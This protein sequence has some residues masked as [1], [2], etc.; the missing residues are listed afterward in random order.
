MKRNVMADETEIQDLSD[1]SAPKTGLAKLSTEERE[2]IFQTVMDQMADSN[3]GYE[4]ICKNIKEELDFRSGEQWSEEDRALREGRPCLTIDKM[5]KYLDKVEGYFRNNPPQANVKARFNA[6]EDDAKII[7]GYL[8]SFLASP[9]T[10][11]CIQT[12]CGH[13]TTVGYGWIYVNYEK[14]S[15]RSFDEYSPVATRVDDPRS[16]RIDKS[17]IEADGSDAAWVSLL[18]TMPRKTAEDR[19]DEELLTSFD[20]VPD[21]YASQWVKDDQI[22]VADYWWKEDVDDTLTEITT[23]D[24]NQK[25]RLFS[26]ELEK[27]VAGSYTVLRTAAA[28]RSVVKMVTVTGAGIVDYIEWPGSDLPII[29]CY[30]AQVWCGEYKVYT[31]LVRKAMD[32]QRLINYYASATAE[33]T[34]LAPR[35]P[36]ILAEQQKE[37]HEAEWDTATVDNF[38]NLTYKHVDGIATPQRAQLTSD[39]SPLLAAITNSTNDLAD[40]MG[41]YEASLG[42]ESNQKSGTAIQN[43]SQNSDQV[44]AIMIDNGRRAVIRMAQVAVN[45]LP[46]LATEE[47]TLRYLSEEGEESE[48]PVNT[49]SPVEVTDVKGID[50]SAVDLSSAVFEVVVEEGESYQTRK[51]ESA[52]GGLELLNILPEAQRGAVAAEVVRNLPWPNSKKL[53]RVLAAMLDPNLRAIIE[54]DENSKEDPQAIAIM[55]G[56]KQEIAQADAESQQKDM[57]IEELQG[58]LQQLQMAVLST[59]QDNDTKLQIAAMKNATDLEIAQLEAGT[60][61][62][63]TAAEIRSSLIMQEIDGRIKRNAKQMDAALKLAEKYLGAIS[64]GPTGNSAGQ[65]RGVPG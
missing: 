49:G 40:V 39:V 26:K 59:A 52:N 22:V 57:Q 60:E 56:M 48:I 45:M 47:R 37:G 23:F 34:A 28:K 25:R 46:F 9:K 10:K 41:I 15:P 51:Q 1:T 62:K 7:K 5:G 20:D 8:R 13:M 2:E 24:T 30:G 6:T 36:F 53:S 4:F 61:V 63:T 32:I 17:S 58:I 42:Q 29:P 31:G 18:R 19:Y 38:S 50:K 12:A 3:D 16:V 64:V 33:V 44:I 11:A 21:E 43:A 27:L 55:E 35:V 14:D 54:G 65:L